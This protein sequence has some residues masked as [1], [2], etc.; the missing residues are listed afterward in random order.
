MIPLPSDDLKGRLIGREGR[1]IRALE[2]ATGIDM[3]IDDTAESI[4]ISC[5][6]PVRR[7]IARL[8]ISALVADGRIHPTRIEEVV[9]KAE[10]EVDKVCKEAGE[11]AVFDLGLHRV[12][13]E[14]V[15]HLGRLKFRQSYA[16]NVLLHS[17]EVGYLAGLIA[18]E[19]GANVK[20]ARRAGL[21][22]DI[23]K[24]VDHEQEGPHA[25]VGAQLARKHG[26]S[27]KV[28]QAIAAHHGDD[29]GVQPTAL[30]DHI[31][32]AANS[33]SAA[34]PGARREQLASYIKRLDDLE[35]ICK[36]FGGVERAYA[37]HGRPRD[38]RDGDE[39]P[40][41]RRAGDRDVQGDRPRDRDRGDV[42]G[43]G[44]RRRRARDPRLRLRALTGGGGGRGRR[45]GRPRGGWIAG[46][47][48]RAE[49]GGGRGAG[50]TGEG[51]GGGPDQQ[52]QHARPRGGG[53]PRRRRKPAG[54]RP[55]WVPGLVTLTLSPARRP[56]PRRRARRTTTSTAIVYRW[57]EG[58]TFN[59]CRKAEPGAFASLA[60]PLGRLLAWLA[61]TDATEPYELTPILERAYRPLVDGRA[62]QRLGAPLADAL[63]QAID[64]AEPQ[65]AWGNVCLVHGDLGGRNL[66]VQRADERWR[67]AGVID[68]EATTTGS[69]LLD[70][71]SLFRYADRYDAEFRADF[72]RGYREA[73][74][75]LP[76]DWLRTARLLDATWLVDTLD[77][78][79]EFPGVYADCRMLLAKL[80]KDTGAG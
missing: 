33:L 70:I 14:L 5:F 13:P 62:R 74:G 64:A 42:S 55:R 49:G 41:R 27:P 11:Q 34:R 7:E 78:P 53:R 6:N 10:K 40:G 12:H 32:A 8:A 56:R 36:R 28:C 72:E 44:P 52:K 9:R 57:I 25:E 67:I 43:P 31:V 59:E 77:E 48:G 15:K 17:V 79:R 69:P 45:A 20:L 46:S 71:G 61:R 35:A 24:A 58:I 4:T 54:G 18:A 65:L 38:P 47:P 63:R 22:H 68:W 39:R 76:D 50:P 60:E 26:E 23:G 37:L 1:N 66:L 51:R 80:A 21:L 73:D 2:A 30:L 29:T 3:I 19:L 16:Q 75:T